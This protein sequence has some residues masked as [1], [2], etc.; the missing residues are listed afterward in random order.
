MEILE[1]MGKGLSLVEVFFCYSIC[2]RIFDVPF[3]LCYEIVL[4]NL[5][6]LYKYI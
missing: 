4:R 2:K 3:S 5:T 6:N 1:K